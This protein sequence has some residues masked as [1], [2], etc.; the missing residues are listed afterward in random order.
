MRVKE[1]KPLSVKSMPKRTIYIKTRPSKLH[2]FPIV[3]KVTKKERLELIK[4][5]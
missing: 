4:L 1:K 2:Q 3:R 5:R